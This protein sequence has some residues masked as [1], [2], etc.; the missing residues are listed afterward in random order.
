MRLKKMLT[1]KNTFFASLVLLL[2][3]LAAILF[4]RF[5]QEKGTAVSLSDSADSGQ[6]AVY[7]EGEKDTAFLLAAP[8][9][10]SLYQPL[11]RELN[12]Q[13]YPV[14]VSPYHLDASWNPD[15]QTAQVEQSAQLLAELSSVEPKNQ[16][17]IGIHD[18]ATALLDQ[19]VGGT[20]SSRAAVLLSPILDSKQIDN[21]IIVNGNYQNQTDWINSLSPDMARQPILFLTSNNDNLS[22]PYQMTLLYNKFSTDEIIHVGGVY[23]AKRN[24]IFLSI[25]DGGFHCL[26]PVQ[27]RTLA[28]ISSFLSQIPQ[29]VSL[30]VSSVPAVQ[31]ILTLC[32]C[33]LLLIVLSCAAATAPSYAPEISFGLPSALS[34]KGKGRLFGVI[35][36][37][38]LVSMLCACAVYLPL[39]QRSDASA[40]A[41]GA[42]LFSFW[43]SARL[44][45]KLFRLK[46]SPAFQTISIPKKNALFNLIALLLFGGCLFIMLDISSLLPLYRRWTLPIVCIVA[47]AVF[48][49]GLFLTLDE[50][51]RENGSMGVRIGFYLIFVLPFLLT[52]LTAAVFLGSSAG[53]YCLILLALLVAHTLLARILFALCGHILPAALLPA[54][55]F[56]LFAV[57][58]PIV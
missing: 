46:I 23:H 31:N 7:Y 4:F 11:L 21:A 52:A 22:T 34:L 44:F 49:L 55:F 20:L 58:F 19:I 9:Y 43:L 1:A 36:L 33:V 50:L 28:E 40:F 10:G 16:V 15:E 37:S 8:Q 29:P 32:A 45:A 27:T 57:I 17:W 54:C 3:Y 41:I 25:I 14:L 42:G 2:V 48:L 24:G 30:P 5:S 38:G 39:G 18:G 26:T 13:G 56:G 12:R 51:L 6:E 53:F 47:G 35:A